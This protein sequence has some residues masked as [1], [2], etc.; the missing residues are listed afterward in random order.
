MD[1][2]SRF[3]S[4]HF[5]GRLQRVQGN[6]SVPTSHFVMST[7]MVVL[8]WLVMQAFAEEMNM[9]EKQELAQASTKSNVSIGVNLSA[10]FND[11]KSKGK[12]FL[13]RKENSSM[14]GLNDS[15]VTKSMPYGMT[16]GV[17]NSSATKSSVK[18]MSQEACRM[19]CRRN[20]NKN[21]AC[22]NSDCLCGNFH[23]IYSN[24]C[25]KDIYCVNYCQGVL[26]WPEALCAH[27]QVT[28]DCLCND[29]FESAGLSC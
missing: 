19:Y 2:C 24:F 15:F 4:N 23:V 13:R 11:T 28:S 22:V 20:K 8:V 18:A 25:T 3:D 9:S 21:G 5:C 17:S 29:G 27:G 12:L 1:D 26:N 16:T 7:F 6:C 10:T 14:S